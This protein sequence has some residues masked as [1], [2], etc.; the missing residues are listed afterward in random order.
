MRIAVVC[1]LDATNF[2]LVEIV[3]VLLKRKHS[4][5]FFGKSL[6]NLNIRMFQGM[7]DEILSLEELD[8]M[9]ES[10]QIEQF[11]CFLCSNDTLFHLL[12]VRKYI[13]TYSITSIFGT[14]LSEGG[15]FMF[16]PGYPCYE[17]GIHEKSVIVPIGN[18]KYDSL[19]STN[20]D[21]KQFLFIDSGHYPF[22]KEGKR[23]VAEIIINIC[24]KFPQYRLVVKPRFLEGDIS[25]TTHRNTNHL[26]ANIRNVCGAN[27]PQNLVLL[28]EY[29]DMNQLINESDTVICMYTSAYLDVAIQGKG[30]IIIDNLPNEDALDLRADFHLKVMRDECRQ[31]GCLVDYHNVLEVLP[32][33]K[34]CNQ[35][36]IK[37]QLATQK[38]SAEKIV[39]LMEYVYELFLSK[40]RL[41][42]INIFHCDSVKEQMKDDKDLTWDILIDNRI[43]N[44]LIYMISRRIDQVDVALRLDKFYEWLE[45]IMRRGHLRE[46]S[47]EE[48]R[49]TSIKI[50]NEI[51][52]AG[53]DELRKSAIGEANLLHA[54][55]IET[56]ESILEIDDRLTKCSRALAYYKANIYMKRGEQE[57][58]IHYFTKYLKETETSDFVQFPSDKAVFEVFPFHKV[59]R[60]T[61]VLIYGAG[62]IGKKMCKF[63]QCTEYAEMCG[64]VDKN[65]RGIVEGKQVFTT[66]SL[67]KVEF[68][69][70]V[71][72]VKNHTI[73]MEVINSLGK[74]GIQ[75]EKIVS[76]YV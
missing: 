11:D 3:K 51:I 62:N 76:Y 24:K 64:F 52:I 65:K 1:G 19:I 68:D 26:Y 47:I 22:G 4:L 71:I 33:G 66:E 10:H 25:S 42:E 34:R 28:Q 41:P 16:M 48:L 21:T 5:V 23:I 74:I 8:R 70:I 59:K 2:T 60:G 7:T 45:A 39:D 55:Y 61:K 15:D 73:N 9:N 14:Y 30:L 35:E 43:Y 49:K 38:C 6:E 37:K 72:S 31:S 12:K 58:A 13:F 18:P 54:M 63:L 40:G 29:G 57:Q 27:L 32:Q 56:P 20:T 67:E 75:S 53:A 69:Y 17:R 36:H 46:Y 44:Y 50:E